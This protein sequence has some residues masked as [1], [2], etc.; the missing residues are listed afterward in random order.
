MTRVRFCLLCA[1]LAGAALLRAE[2]LPQFRGGTNTVS[3]HATV[4]DRSNRLVTNLNESDFE[5]YDNGRLQKTT[6][7]ANDV[8]PITIVVMLDRSG[9]MRSHFTLVSN[10]AEQFVGNLL[11]GDRARIGSFSDE[12]RI[13][14]AA[15]TSDHAALLDV[16]RHSLLPPGMTPLWN[17]TSLAMNALANEPGRRVIL[18]FTDGED[19]PGI[20]QNVSYFE[21][22]SRAQTE[23]VMVY[24]IGFAQGCDDAAV[25]RPAGGP[26]ADA[27]GQRG[28]PPS[29]PGGGRIPGRPPSGPTGGG[30]PPMPGLPP[31]GRGFPPRQ[32]VDP[33]FADPVPC[34]PTSPDPGLRAL[35]DV[36]GGG[37]FELHAV[38]N[39]ASTFARV[40]EELH[41]QYLLAFTAQVMDGR[42]HEIDVRVKGGGA[43]V[44]ARRSY[45]AH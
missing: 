24:A 2:Q 27:A 15:F 10:A 23:E 36:G 4:L 39:L 45:W 16:L 8:R 35:A 41:H 20:G 44:R 13:Q 26:R 22:R 12:I 5:I 9:S 31:P 1:V 3:I 29:V 33:R 43:V 42:L 28:R 38:D 18:L 32:P 21:V 40:A 25:A 17:A 34:K 19:T 6:V 30:W 37:Y 7:F 11:P 14:P